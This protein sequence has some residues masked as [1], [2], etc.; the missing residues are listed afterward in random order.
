MTTSIWTWIFENIPVYAVHRT[1]SRVHFCDPQRVNTPSLGKVQKV[2]NDQHV[3]FFRRVRVFD[4]VMNATPTRAKGCFSTLLCDTCALMQQHRQPDHRGAKCIDTHDA[5]TLVK[6]L[7]A[8][9]YFVLTTSLLN[10][11]YLFLEWVTGIGIIGLKISAWNCERRR[12]V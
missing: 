12:N 10:F 1:I 11:F 7:S 2:G 3:S 8:V 6:C 5:S 9:R 4:D